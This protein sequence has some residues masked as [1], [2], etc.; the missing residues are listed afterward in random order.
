SEPLPVIASE[1]C[2]VSMPLPVSGS[3]S[4]TGAE[5]DGTITTGNG[6]SGEVNGR[7]FGPNAEEVGGSVVATDTADPF[8]GRN[9]V[10]CYSARQTTP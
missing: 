9:L 6:L 4:L 7:L 1:S 5:L 10:A 2:S 8:S 3:G